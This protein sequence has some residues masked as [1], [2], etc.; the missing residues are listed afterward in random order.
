MDFDPFQPETFDSP[1]Q[2]HAELR[3]KCPVA[4][5]DR[6]NGFWTLTKFDDIVDVLTDSST[7]IT[8]VQNVVP[9]VAFTGRRPPLHLDPPAHTPYRRALNPLFAEARMKALEPRIRA[10]TRKSLLE[11]IPKGQFD[12]VQDF[13]VDMPVYTFA[14]F[15]N[16]DD[17]VMGRIHEVAVIFARAVSGANDELVKS[18]SLQLYAIARD[19]IEKR[20]LLPLDPASD[21]TTALLNARDEAGNPLPDDMILGTL[22]QVLVVGIIA[23]CVTIGSFVVHLARNP[24]LQAA[25][26]RTARIASRC[27]RRTHAPLHALPRL[28]PHRKQRRRDPRLPHSPR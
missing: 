5:S 10:Y 18:S 24:E 8:S 28:R 27:T 7:Y 20:K 22:R 15:L 23:P 19:L 13:S 21:P 2:V 11:Q 17:I 26:P 16:V 3:A 25:A 4:H 6:W 9:R 12:I 14:E 1:H